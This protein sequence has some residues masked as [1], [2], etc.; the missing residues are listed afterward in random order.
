MKRVLVCVLDWGLGHATRS[1]PVIR[2]LQ[3]QGAKVF[4]AS[5]Q[6]AGKLLQQEF[7]ALSYYELPG[8]S[9]VYNSGGS[10]ML[11]I[12]SQAF[13][14]A[15]TIRREH[16]EVE[17]L[18]R[19]HQI[20]R[21]ISD[22]RYGCYAEAIPSVFITHQYRVRLPRYWSLFEG[23]VN[24]WL[25][26]RYARY[27]HLWIPDQPGSGLTDWFVPKGALV[28]YVG[29]LSRFGGE[30]SQASGVEIVATVSGP[31]PQRR[32]FADKLRRELMDSGRCALLVTGQPGN[33]FR[34]QQG[35]LTVV[36]HLPAKELEPALRGAAVVIARSG[37]STIMD[38]I[39]LG[40]KAVLVPTPQQ[41][42]QLYLARQ[43]SESKVAF[44][45]DQEN[46]VLGKALQEAEGFPGFVSFREEEGKLESAIR[47]LLV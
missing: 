25:K 45:V 17:E 39:A 2:E 7:P 11:A 6:E 24:G 41:P 35:N 9:P 8:Y 33:A 13:R 43:L 29:W 10:L 42:E 30:M 21:V 18:V 27:Q 37:Y 22:N 4:I 32:I 26:T 38:L 12:A 1:V 40:K 15:R 47:Q 28:T 19:S 36:N 16:R 14:F 23:L 46:F 44:C 5:S 20:D 3:R 34:E 31:E